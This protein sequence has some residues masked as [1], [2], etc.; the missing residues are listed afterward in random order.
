MDRV[1]S[2]ASILFSK[3]TGGGDW[4]A[5]WREYTTGV[6][7]A[8]RRS[9]PAATALSDRVARERAMRTMNWDCAEKEEGRGR[10]G[11]KET[12][13]LQKKM[14]RTRDTETS[15]RFLTTSLHRAIFT[16]RTQFACQ[17]SSTLYVINRLRDRQEK[18]IDW[19]KGRR[20][21]YQRLENM[22]KQKKEA[23]KR[24]NRKINKWLVMM[25]R[26]WVF[27]S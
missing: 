7:K 23:K 22:N 16:S 14:A 24:G 18:W 26:S 21:W 9:E 13:G 6:V 1:L 3:W 19:E 4:W 25:Y 11:R 12:Q 10:K 5:W 2:L 20:E 17:A 15:A 8:P 27:G